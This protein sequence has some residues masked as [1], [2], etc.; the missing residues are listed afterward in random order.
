MVLG[1][2]EIW[3]GRIYFII[4]NYRL[5]CARHHQISIVPACAWRAGPRSCL[6]FGGVR[7]AGRP[8][9][10]E[11]LASGDRILR[12]EIGH[13]SLHQTGPH[14]SPEIDLGI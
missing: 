12:S 14:G 9:D 1:P 3:I 7:G 13:L 4:F 8:H 10:Y 6:G 11:P 5:Q 2:L